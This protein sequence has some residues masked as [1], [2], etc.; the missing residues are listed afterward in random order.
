[1][2]C[3]YALRDEADDAYLTTYFGANWLVR[4]WRRVATVILMTTYLI[5]GSHW[6][7]GYID[8]KRQ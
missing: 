3:W 7:S 2:N 6:C 4:L 1:M 5:R 8:S